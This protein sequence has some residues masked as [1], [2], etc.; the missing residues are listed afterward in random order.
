[1]AI[2][3]H[4]A[5][6]RT[7]GVRQLV[8]AVSDH[9][10][11][12][13]HLAQLVAARLQGPEHGLSEVIV[14]M[15]GQLV[16]GVDTEHCPATL[17]HLHVLVGSDLLSVRYV[18]LCEVGPSRHEP[19]ILGLVVEG[20]E[21]SGL[22]LRLGEES[23][24]DATG[25]TVEEVLTADVLAMI[26]LGVHLEE[27]AGQGVGPD[28]GIKERAHEVH[29]L[30]GQCTAVSKDCWKVEVKAIWQERNGLRVV[31]HESVRVVLSTR[32]HIAP[33][34]IHAGSAEI[35]LVLLLAPM[36]DVSP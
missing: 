30:H 36:A 7:N 9:E 23:C 35:I 4:G 27:K 5:E 15:L 33:S 17:L 1:M 20:G 12:E 29:H 16:R 13:P 14:E 6:H 32:V 31:A 18:R 24:G 11:T 26:S 25:S 28:P 22:R 2:C 34:R 10:R 3:L 19:S 21:H 8:M